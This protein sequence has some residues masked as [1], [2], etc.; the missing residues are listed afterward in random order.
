MNNPAEELAFLRKIIT[1]SRRSVVDNGMTFI[2]WGV[3]V[4]IGVGAIYVELLSNSWKWSGWVWLVCIAGGIAY[5]IYHG[6][7]E[8]KQPVRPFVDKLLGRLWSALG[9]SMAIVAVAGGYSR[10]ISPMAISPLI[11]SF[12]AVSYYVSGIIYDLKWFRNL[13][14]GWWAGAIVLFAWDSVHTLGL[15][16]LLMIALQIIPGLMLYK[17][18]KE[19]AVATGSLE[20][21]A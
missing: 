18:W 9:I 12:L 8:V 3:L 5:S 16:C 13:A 14:Y 20:A 15:Y 11:A 2:V 4:T 7:R 6:A 19:Q 10:Q 1:D 17:R 21:I